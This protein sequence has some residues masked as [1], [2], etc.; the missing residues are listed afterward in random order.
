MATVIHML[1]KC[2]L[3]I[4]TANNRTFAKLANIYKYICWQ[5]C[6][7]LRLPFGKC[8][9]SVPINCFHNSKIQ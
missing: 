6:T 5:V 8:L 4:T 3:P 2:Y 1:G 7:Q 9:A